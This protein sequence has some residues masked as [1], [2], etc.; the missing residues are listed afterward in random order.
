M[1]DLLYELS[2]IER[3]AARVQTET[4]YCNLYTLVYDFKSVSK[5]SIKENIMSKPVYAEEVILT[6]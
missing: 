1:V 5:F 4:Y 2:F 3:R 6:G